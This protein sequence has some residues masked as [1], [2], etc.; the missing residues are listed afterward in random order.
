MKLREKLK[1]LELR[2]KGLAY[3]YILNKVGVSKS[4]LSLWLKDVELSALNKQKILKGLEKSRQ[5]AALARINKRLDNTKQVVDR[6]KGNFLHL[7]SSKLFLVGLSLY[8]A[9]GDKNQSEKVKFT[10]SDDRMIR[11]MMR[12]F[13]EICEIPES[14]FRIALHLHSLQSN[15]RAVLY[16]SRVTGVPI[17]QF[18]KVYVKKTSLGQRKNVLYNGTCGI[19]INSKTLFRTIVGWKLGLIEYFCTSP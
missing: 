18:Y 16:W 15:K 13:R 4:T 1:A 17:R 7:V 11:L 9:E 2:K 3:S 19:T 6:A 14:K 10:N 5:L 12:W 8:W